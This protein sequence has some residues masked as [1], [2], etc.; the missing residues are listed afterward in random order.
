MQKRAFGMA[1]ASTKIGPRF[2]RNCAK[3]SLQVILALRDGSMHVGMATFFQN[4]G[5]LISD[6]DVYRHEISMADL[7]EPLV[8]VVP[9]NY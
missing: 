3:G 4:I 1:K 5:R 2:C 8:I 6:H 7:A 9:T